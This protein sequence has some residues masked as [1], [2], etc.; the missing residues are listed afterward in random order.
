MKS[1]SVSLPALPP[2]EEERL[3][4][5]KDRLKYKILSINV[6]LG[7]SVSFNQELASFGVYYVKTADEV[8]VWTDKV[9]S[10]HNG[11]IKRLS[12]TE[13]IRVRPGYALMDLAPLS[14]VCT[15]HS[16]SLCR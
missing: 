14:A 4:A 11:T 15:L 1:H 8:R 12:V 3:S 5:L 13:G 7:D 16:L 6:R 9:R 10:P 2:E